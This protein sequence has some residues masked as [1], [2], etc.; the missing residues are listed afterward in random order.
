MI[1]IAFLFCALTC[2][3]PRGWRGGEAGFVG[4]LH[5]AEAGVA[6]CPVGL[7]EADGVALEG[8]EVPPHLYGVRKS[9]AADEHELC[10]CTQGNRQGFTATAEIGEFVGGEVLAGNVDLA[11]EGEHGVFEI[12][13]QGQCEFGGAGAADI[14]AE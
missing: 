7:G 6:T 5:G 11:A 3:L 2:V 8:D 14:Q 13:L 4:A 9:F 12:R 10:A 1:P